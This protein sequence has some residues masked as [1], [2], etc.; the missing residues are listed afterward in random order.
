MKS[1]INIVSVVGARPNFI[2]VAPLDKEFDKYK[3]KFCHKICH[4]G[5]H[6]D[7]NMS[8]VFFEDLDLPEPDYYLGVGSGSHAVQTAKIMI[9]F[10]KVLKKENPDL[11]IVFGDI[12]STMACSIVAS[13]LNIKIAHV[14][15][16]LRSFDRGMPEEIN[17]IITDKLSDLLFVSEESGL[18]NLAKEG[19][20]ESKIFFVG[21]IMIDS[22]VKY[23]DKIENS[24]IVKKY[25]LKK[26]DYV[27][28]TF[29]RPSNV[30]SDSDIK[31]LISLLN[32][33]SNRKKVIFPIHPRT[34]KKIEEI[35][36]INRI[37]SNIIV[38]DPL[39][40]FDFLCLTKNALIVITDSGGIQ[41]ESTFMNVQC[42]TMRN[43]TERPV[44]IDI[45]TNQLAGSNTLSVKKIANNIFDGNIKN[46]Q[47]PKL[48]D[49]KT[50]QRIVDV[51]LKKF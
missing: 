47:I 6:F 30:D 45:G 16:G 43:N 46:G 11:I 23:W 31:S 39:G 22:L 33:I 14:E 9:E 42:I 2:K 50:A 27:L 34:L 15:S 24:K 12:N 8:K 3:E 1:L 5:Q 28:A 32:E 40:Y 25:K 7:E 21:N 20:N 51:L 35:K 4:T 37:N 13:K 19:V 38:T 10:E 44:T 18:N 48:W 26:N 29:H 36:I 17:R 49:G 41:E